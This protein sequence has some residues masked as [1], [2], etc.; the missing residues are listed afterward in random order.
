MPQKHANA[1]V[2][3][4]A[5]KDKTVSLFVSDAFSRFNAFDKELKRSDW[6]QLQ[7][8]IN[9]PFHSRS[10]QGPR[11]GHLVTCPHLKHTGASTDHL[12]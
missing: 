6:L 10:P 5:T 3:R 11:R 1:T 2:C 4:N 8:N 7:L 9:K 12:A